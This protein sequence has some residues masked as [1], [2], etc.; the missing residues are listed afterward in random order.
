MLKWP[1][2]GRNSH[3]PDDILMSA[4]TNHVNPTP[5]HTSFFWINTPIDSN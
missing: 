4:F 1:K 2:I 3:T 5:P